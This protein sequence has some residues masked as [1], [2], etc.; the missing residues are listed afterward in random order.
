MLIYLE[1]CAFDVFHD[2]FKQDG[3]LSLYAEE[4]LIVNQNFME[5]FEEHELPEYII[6]LSLAARRNIKNFMGSLKEMD[7]LFEKA[8]FDEDATLGVLR[9]AAFNNSGLVGFCL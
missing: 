1:L 2:N 4:F 8:S 6:R 5:R 3:N 9:K 7:C